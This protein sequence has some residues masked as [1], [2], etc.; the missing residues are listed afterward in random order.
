MTGKIL[1][2]PP[3]MTPRIH[4]DLPSRGGIPKGWAIDPETGK[5]YEI[6]ADDDIVTDDDNEKA[7]LFVLGAIIVVWLLF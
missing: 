7:I 2:C 3:P 6:V 5:P 1:S 4:V